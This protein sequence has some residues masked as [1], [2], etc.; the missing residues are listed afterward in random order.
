MTF[1]RRLMRGQRKPLHRILDNLPAHKTRAVKAYVAKMK[2]KLSLHFLTGYAPE[3]N[4]DELVWNHAKRTG[5]ARRPLHAGER[6]EIAS[7]PSWPTWHQWPFA[8]RMTSEPCRG[9]GW[10]GRSIQ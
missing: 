1:L 9:L 7:S 5:N 2:G 3:L 10:S 8:E 6:L 4:P